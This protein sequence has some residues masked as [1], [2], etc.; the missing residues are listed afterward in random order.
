MNSVQRGAHRAHL[1][2]TQGLRLLGDTGVGGQGGVRLPRQMG[3]QIGQMPQAFAAAKQPP[4][5]L[6]LPALQLGTHSG[7]GAR[8][9]ALVHRGKNGVC[10]L[11]LQLLRQPSAACA[12]GWGR[13]IAP[14][15]PAHDQHV[16]ARLHLGRNH[17]PQG[18]RFKLG[19]LCARGINVCGWH[20]RFTQGLAGAGAG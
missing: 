6:L 5:R 8:G 15:G 14:I 20:P 2:K 4:G 3:G 12:L 7:G 17:S 11:V 18:F 9:V 10:A 16:V 13:G 1:A 19:C